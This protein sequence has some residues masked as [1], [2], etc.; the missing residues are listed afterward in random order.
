MRC[1]PLKSSRGHG[2]RR[3]EPSQKNPDPSDKLTAPLE[4]STQNNSDF[5]HGEFGVAFPFF[6]LVFVAIG[7]FKIPL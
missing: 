3:A 2:K 7:A 6:C 1:R 5:D 4:R